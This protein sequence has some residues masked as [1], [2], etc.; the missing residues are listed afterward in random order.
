MRDIILVF[1]FGILTGC[2]MWAI[3]F[4]IIPAMRRR[5][6]LFDWVMLGI[7]LGAISVCS[8]QMG[9]LLRDISAN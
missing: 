6:K 3:I 8:G 7:S 9:M 1:I 2:N 4:A 5:E